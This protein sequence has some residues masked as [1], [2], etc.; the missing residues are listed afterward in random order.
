MPGPVQ[1]LS[2]GVLSKRLSTAQAH[3]AARH[4]RAKHKN[5][6]TKNA[7]AA[8]LSPMCVRAER[9][10]KELRVSPLPPAVY[11]RSLEEAQANNTVRLSS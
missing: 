3:S 4:A 1:R 7:T 8:A 5:K 6:L 11:G 2:Y 9:K 10:Q